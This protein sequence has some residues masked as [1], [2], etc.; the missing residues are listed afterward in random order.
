MPKRDKTYGLEVQIKIKGYD[1]YDA[2]KQLNNALAD[3]L[4]EPKFVIDAVILPDRDI[5][6][7]D[8]ESE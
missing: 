7:F 8:T 2:L 3:G 4:I 1:E 5:V 6:V